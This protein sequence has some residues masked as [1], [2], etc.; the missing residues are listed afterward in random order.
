[1]STHPLLLVPIN[2][3]LTKLLPFIGLPV[4][5]VN[6]VDHQTDLRDLQG[7]PVPSAPVT[8]SFPVLQVN[9]QRQ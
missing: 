2:G 9:T 3:A 1:M 4:Q 7:R 6:G 8:P 5:P